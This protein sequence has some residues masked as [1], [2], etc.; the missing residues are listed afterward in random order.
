MFP[1]PLSVKIADVHAALGVPN[2]LPHVSVIELGKSITKA[3][4][5]PPQEESKPEPHQVRY[6]PAPIYYGLGGCG[7][8]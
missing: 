7:G 2:P 8:D 1:I 5:R 3:V 6:Y 4:S